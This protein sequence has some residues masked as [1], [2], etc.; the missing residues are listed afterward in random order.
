[1]PGPGRSCPLAYRYPPE[2]LAGPAAFEATTLYVVGGLYGNTC[3]L[4]AVVRRAAAEPIPPEV[5]FN[6]DFHY[7]DAHPSAFRAIADGVL[8]RRATLGNV[9]YALTADAVELGCG[10]DY[11]D[12]IGDTVV[13]DSNAVVERLRGIAAGFPEHLARLAELPRHLTVTV[14]GRR[15]AIVHGDPESL[16]GWKLAL[17]AVEPGDETARASIGWSGTSTSTRVIADW[18]IRADVEVICCTHTGLPYAQDVQR[19]AHRYLVANSGSAGLPN[20]TGLRHGVITRLSTDPVAP[21]DSLYG[22]DLA[23]LSF[24]ALPVYYDI[25][26]WTS[27]FLATWPPGTPGHHGYNPR[28]TDGTWL[29]L[30]QAARGRVRLTPG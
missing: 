20:F 1:M 23:G 16:A 15:V 10:C 11:P 12:Y 18:C 28:V 7:L 8:A 27:E 2:D 5:V 29:R 6:G 14:G 24:A 22:I 21:A 30:E 3:A 26:R 9:E 25:D 13:A 17:E 4:D 19:D